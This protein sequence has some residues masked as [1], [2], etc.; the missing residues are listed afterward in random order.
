MSFH[1]LN[2]YIIKSPRSRGDTEKKI[3]CF[4]ISQSSLRQKDGGQVSG[5]LRNDV[6]T[7]LSYQIPRV[8]RLFVILKKIKEQNQFEPLISLSSHLFQKNKILF[9][10]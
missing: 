5:L 10:R 6:Y 9:I 3:R 2:E 4:M 7:T 1:F 8:K